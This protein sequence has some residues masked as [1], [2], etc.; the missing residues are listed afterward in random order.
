M[1]P[2]HFGL[3]ENNVALVASSDEHSIVRDQS[4][5]VSEVEQGPWRPISRH[6]GTLDGG[7][8][9]VIRSRH[10]ADD[11]R[12]AQTPAPL[13]RGILEESGHFGLDVAE[14]V[15]LVGD[16]R[17][18]GEVVGSSR[19]CWAVLQRQIGLTEESAGQFTRLD[20]APEDA[21]GQTLDELLETTFQIAGDHNGNVTRTMGALFHDIGSDVGRRTSDSLSPDLPGLFPCG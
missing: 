2:A 18:D 17:G 10:D 14:V 9:L 16:L 4:P 19:T 6:E 15:A 7:T 8:A 12:P 20:R 3:R 13:S 21:S 5:F 11:D 1:G